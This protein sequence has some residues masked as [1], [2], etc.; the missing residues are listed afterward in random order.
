MILQICVP[1]YN[2]CEKV[3]K[4]VDFL[5][6]EINQLDADIGIHVK[7]NNSTDATFSELQKKFKSIPYIK[8]SKNDTNVGLVGNLLLLI[9]ESQGQYTWLVGDDDILH[10]GI[11]KEVI[12]AINSQ[13][14]LIFI[15]HDAYYE[16]GKMAF[17]TA[18]PRRQDIDLLD[19]FNFSFG[20]V[21]FITATVYKTNIIKEITQHQQ[22]AQYSPRLSSPLYWALKAG[23]MGRL[24]ILNKIL[25]TNIWGETS[26]KNERYKVAILNVPTE[27][28]KCIF[29]SYSKMRVI[30]SILN[31]YLQYG[32]KFIK[33][34][35]C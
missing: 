6:S 35:L 10:P 21:M 25:I 34:L 14:N 31:Y 20:S 11:L 17:S 22:S 12:L 23:S 5:I 28:L 30:L 7:D 29:S 1:T 18:L 19:V 26:W 16:D 33:K 8:I 24:S 9:S 2:R 3:L 15:N 32:I 13:P 4:T 27:I